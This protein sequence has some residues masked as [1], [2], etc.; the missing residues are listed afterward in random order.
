[1]YEKTQTGR[2]VERNGS[3]VTDGSDDMS[4]VLTD[5]DVEGVWSVFLLCAVTSGVVQTTVNLKTAASTRPPGTIPALGRL[6]FRATRPP[7]EVTHIASTSL[8]PRYWAA[9]CWLVSIGR[10]TAK[11][12]RYSSSRHA[13]TCHRTGTEQT[14]IDI[15]HFPGRRGNDR[16]LTGM[17][18]HE[19]LDLV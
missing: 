7:T 15:L 10:W 8:P 13:L 4:S 12:P 3:E 14:Q 2:D 6:I 17:Y 1:M 16:T 19:A 11:R 18:I 5:V 9:T